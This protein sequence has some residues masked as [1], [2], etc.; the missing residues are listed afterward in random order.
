MLNTK[1]T[2]SENKVPYI[3][4]LATKTALNTKVTKIES[5][6]PDITKLATKAALNTKAT[7]I[8]NKKLDT[9]SYITTSEFNR[10]TKISLNAR[11]IEIAKSFA[12]KNHV[13]NA[14]N[15][16]D[17]NREKIEKIQR[18]YLSYFI[19]NDVSLVTLIMT[20][21]KPFN[22]LINL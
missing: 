2:E 13:D 14:L 7:E 11:I 19:G 5:K 20:D 21:C 22:I 15:M 10:L 12:S 6:I 3:T 8:E 9:T 16:A 1:V 4:N 17:K 18:F